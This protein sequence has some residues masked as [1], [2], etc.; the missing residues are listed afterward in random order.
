MLWLPESQRY[1]FKRPFG[2]LYRSFGDVLPRLD[3]RFLCTVGDVVT[4]NAVSRGI[5]VQVGII[6]GYSMRMPCGKTPLLP[7][8]R[9][10]TAK[11][12]AGTITTALTSAIEDALSD[13]PAI[14]FVEGEEDLAVLPLALAAP[15]GALLLY[16]QPG[17]GV[18]V[19]EIDEE[20]RVEARRLLSLFLRDEHHV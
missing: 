7:G 9:R 3:S 14:I 18:V 5:V 17:E 4:Y 12:P 1:A 13:P 16:G 11:N 20:A 19:R 8:A 10:L 2:T 15:D 6:D